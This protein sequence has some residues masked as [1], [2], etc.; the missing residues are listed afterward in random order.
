VLGLDGTDGYEAAAAL[1]AEQRV[2]S[3]VGSSATGLERT[4]SMRSFTSQDGRIA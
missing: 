3:A 4:A 1:D 2:P